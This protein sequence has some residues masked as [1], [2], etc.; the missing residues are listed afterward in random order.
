LIETRPERMSRSAWRG[1]ARRA[2]APN[3]ARSVRAL[4]ID[5]ISIAQQAS[6]KVAGKIELARAV[7]SAFSRVVV[8]TLCST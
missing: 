5:I 3:R 1:E 8:K 6:P 4:I 7:L 2:S